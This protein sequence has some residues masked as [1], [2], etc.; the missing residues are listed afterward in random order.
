MFNE[1]LFHLCDCTCSN[2]MR[3]LNCLMIK[4]KKIFKYFIWFWKCFYDFVS[5]E[6][7][8]KS[9]FPFCSKTFPDVFSQV[10]CEQTLLV[11]MRMEKFRYHWNSDREFCNWLTSKS[12]LQKLLMCFNGHFASNFVRSLPTKWAIL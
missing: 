10:S 5:L 3:I 7:C 9:L 8:P 4:P 2:V 12:Y 11:K 1:G 6:F